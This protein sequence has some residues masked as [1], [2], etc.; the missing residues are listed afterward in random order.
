[1]SKQATF[2]S[3][4]LGAESTVKL[5]KAAAADPDASVVQAWYCDTTC[6]DPGFLTSGGAAVDGEN[7]AIALNPLT[8]EARIPTMAAYVRAMKTL[9]P[10]TVAGLESYSAGLLFQQTVHQVAAASGPNSITRVRLLATLGT[11]HSFTAGGILGT[12]DVAARQP[13][14][15]YVLLRVDA[16]RFARVFPDRADPAGLRTPES[17]D[18]PHRR[19]T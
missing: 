9:G 4:G 6:A 5:R 8:D 11:V 17:P 7:V 10:P 19:L 3:S 13:T 2:A 1:M 18:R 14:G 16:G 12:T 15:C